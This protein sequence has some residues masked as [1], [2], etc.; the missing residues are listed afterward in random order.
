MDNNYNP[1]EQQLVLMLSEEN[2]PK[3]NRQ[4]V[5]E[6]H[7]KH[8]VTRSQKVGG[9]SRFNKGVKTPVTTGG[10]LIALCQ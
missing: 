6:R 9:N 4:V 5:R 1:K 2:L 7:M 8:D 3:G 10:R